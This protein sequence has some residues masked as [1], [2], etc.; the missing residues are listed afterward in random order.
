MLSAMG[1][2]DLA[3]VARKRIVYQETRIDL[4]MAP[5][6]FVTSTLNQRKLSL[7]QR[8]CPVLCFEEYLIRR[9]RWLAGLDGRF[10]SL[11]ADQ[12]L[13]G[14]AADQGDSL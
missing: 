2:I 14:S 11:R 9:G 6:R 3:L 5:S 1:S 12:V 10:V 7:F 8:R 4:P 13:G